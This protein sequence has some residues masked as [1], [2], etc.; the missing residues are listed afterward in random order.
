MRQ[1]PTARFNM[2]PFE[3][4]RDLLRG[5]DAHASIGGA[6]Q[7]VKIYQYLSSAYLGV[8]WPKVRKGRLFLSGRPLL[9]YERAT[10][11]SVL[12]PDTLSSTWCNGSPEEAAAQLRKANRAARASPSREE[13][14]SAELIPS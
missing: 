14:L 2:E 10:I 6:P 3:V 11:K 13:D 8:F 12:D 7:G 9:D 5:A 1:P 4:I